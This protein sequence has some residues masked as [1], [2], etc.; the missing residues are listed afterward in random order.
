MGPGLNS[1]RMWCS[2]I[3]IWGLTKLGGYP[4]MPSFFALKF[5]L[6]AFFTPR[7]KPLHPYPGSPHVSSYL[8]PFLASRVGHRPHGSQTRS[9]PPWEQYVV[10]ALRTSPKMIFVFVRCAVPYLR[11]QDYPCLTILPPHGGQLVNLKSPIFG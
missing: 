5:R 8:P 2:D 11:S 6:S 7:P 1:Q 10:K 9:R 4:P 3:L